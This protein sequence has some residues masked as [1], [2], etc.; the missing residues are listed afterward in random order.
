MPLNQRTLKARSEPTWTV[1]IDH[2]SRVPL[3][4]GIDWTVGMRVYFSLKQAGP[5]GLVLSQRPAGLHEGRLLSARIQR[6][7]STQRAPM[8]RTPSRSRR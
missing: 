1:H 7:R 8:R 5:P 6:I 4:P 3:P 2:R